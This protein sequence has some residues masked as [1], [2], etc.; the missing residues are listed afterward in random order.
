MINHT[1]EKSTNSEPSAWMAA[2]NN[3]CK[4]SLGIIPKLT[5]ILNHTC[6]VTMIKELTEMS[7]D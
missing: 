7:F 6:Q 2:R 1:S 5:Q 3:F 4:K